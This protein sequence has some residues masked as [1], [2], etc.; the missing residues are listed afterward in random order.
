MYGGL[1]VCHIFRGGWCMEPLFSLSLISCK[2]QQTNIY[3]NIHL[4]IHSCFTLV[5]VGLVR[6]A[7]LKGNPISLGW[8]GWPSAHPRA[9]CTSHLTAAGPTPPSCKK[10]IPH[11]ALQNGLLQDPTLHPACEELSATLLVSAFWGNLPAPGL[12]FHCIMTSS[13]KETSTQQGTH[14][15]SSLTTRSSRICTASRQPERLLTG[16]FGEAR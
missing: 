8:P 3:S 16:L 4:P 13:D 2:W 7:K 9:S 15:Q 14:S 10:S 5:Q 12:A 11:L 6:A 1:V